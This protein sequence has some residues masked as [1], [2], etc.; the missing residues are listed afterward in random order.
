MEKTAAIKGSAIAR[1]RFFRK[2]I[3]QQAYVDLFEWTK[4]N[5]AKRN[6][7]IARTTR[8]SETRTISSPT[9][10]RKAPEMNSPALV[11]KPAFAAVSWFKPKN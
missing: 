3:M 2:D 7:G 11:P 5:A 9:A 4:L 10:A 1:Y 8:R 6:R